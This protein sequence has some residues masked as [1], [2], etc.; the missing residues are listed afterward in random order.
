MR[1]PRIPPGLKCPLWV[2]HPA[3]IHTHL[4]EQ[5]LF[6][7]F[8]VTAQRERER[9]TIYL[10]KKLQLK[11]IIPKI[12]VVVHTTSRA[13]KGDAQYFDLNYTHTGSFFFFSVFSLTERRIEPSFT[14]D[15]FFPLKNWNKKITER[16]FFRWKV[17]TRYRS[18]VRMKSATG[19]G[20]SMQG[21]ISTRNGF[22][23]IFETFRLYR[24]VW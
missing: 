18:G 22:F 2:L 17:L 11:L 16:H 4:S 7:T 23:I 6:I 9:D 3:H 24:T 13:K 14:D 10:N 12:K 8:S 19:W 5:F 20:V 1:A 21:S 15:L